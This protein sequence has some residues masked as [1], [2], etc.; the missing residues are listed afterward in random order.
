MLVDPPAPD[1][2]ETLEEKLLILHGD[3]TVDEQTRIITNRII[4]LRE[5]GFSWDQA[6]WLGARYFGEDKVDVHQVEDLIKAGATPYQAARI[7]A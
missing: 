2:E 4:R 1:W 6:S 5:L 7:V 3:R